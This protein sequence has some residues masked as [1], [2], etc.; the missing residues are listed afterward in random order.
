MCCSL[1]TRGHRAEGAS[2]RLLDTWHSTGIDVKYSQQVNVSEARPAPGS[3]APRAASSRT[4]G[5]HRTFVAH[6]HLADVH[7]DLVA[8]APRALKDG[9]STTFFL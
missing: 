3:K 8:F 4:A 1:R 6:D 2:A 7:L 5:L 9:G